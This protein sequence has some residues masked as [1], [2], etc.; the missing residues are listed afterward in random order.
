MKPIKAIFAVMALVLVLTACASGTPR[1]PEPLPT[2]VPLSTFTPRPEPTA[3]RIP[4]PTATPPPA[5]TPTPKPKPTPTPA[6]SPTPTPTPAPTATPVPTA[7]TLPT[8]TPI[9]PLAP[10][11]ER[12]NSEPPHV[13]AG[14][15]TI[16]GAPAPNG[17]EVTV[18]LEEFNAPL[19]A[20]T[21]SGGDYSVLAI[22]HGARSF[23]GRTLIFKVNGQD[24][25]ETAIWEKGGATSLA[26]S[27]N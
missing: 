3:T 24:S 11:P 13:F 6:P 1:T 27:L 8:A 12:D 9:P 4:E 23:E 20:G 14:S 2:L 15:V 7:T 25:G 17:T 10:L 16:N 5:P 19:G 26:V 22:Q 18:W 21:S